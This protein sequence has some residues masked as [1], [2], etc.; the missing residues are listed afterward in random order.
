MLKR[1][2]TCLLVLCTTTVFAASDSV[3]PT[4]NVRLERTVA[5]AEIEGINYDN[6]SIVLK[7]SSMWGVKVIVRDVKT[8]KKVYKKRFASSYL[9]A[10]A[11]GA[12]VV[13]VGNA[14]IQVIITKSIMFG[15]WSAQ[16]K[17]NGL[18]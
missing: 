14:L 18:Y 4:F 7:S 11:D 9:Y 13:G 5:F 15:Y 8:C 12:I 3:G 6:V 16:I 17:K 2:I 1:V 10:H